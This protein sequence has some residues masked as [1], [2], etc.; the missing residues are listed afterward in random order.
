[1]PIVNNL[2]MKLDGQNILVYPYTV[3]R[4]VYINESNGYNLIQAL[5]DLRN[6][7]T[8]EW[9]DV[10]NKPFSAIGTDFKVVDG[11][12]RLNG[13]FSMEWSE[14]QN[15]PTVFNS[16]WGRITGKPTMYP[17]DWSM[18]TN[19]PSIYNSDWESVANKPEIFLTNWNSINEKP[20][21]FDSEWFAMNNKPFNLINGL[22][23]YVDTNDHLNI[24]QINNRKFVR[25]TDSFDN[26]TIE[27]NIPYILYN[28]QVDENNCLLE[29]LNLP[30]MMGVRFVGST[31]DAKND[32]DFY[33]ANDLGIKS[34]YYL[35]IDNNTHDYSKKYILPANSSHFFSIP[36][37]FNFYTRGN[38]NIQNSCGL[39][40]FDFNYI[41][42][43]CYLFDHCNLNGLGQIFFNYFPT[44]NANLSNLFYN[45]FDNRH[46]ELLNLTFNNL[47]YNG[48]DSNNFSNLF[49]SEKPYNINCISIDNTSFIWI[50]DST[51]QIYRL[52][53]NNVN[54][55]IVYINGN[56]NF[57]NTALALSKQQ[58][59]LNYLSFMWANVQTGWNGG[60]QLPPVLLYN[61]YF[62]TVN[63][64]NAEYMPATYNGNGDIRINC[65]DSYTGNPPQLAVINRW[66][67][68]SDKTYINVY[69]SS[70]S[71][72]PKNMLHMDL[73]QEHRS[74]MFNQSNVI[75]NAQI[76]GL[77]FYNTS[78]QVYFPFHANQYTIQ[79]PSFTLHFK[80]NNTADS[81]WIY[82]PDGDC[83][84]VYDGDP[85]TLTKLEICFE[86]YPNLESDP[87]YTYFTKTF[88]QITLNFINCT[89]NYG[90]FMV[91]DFLGYSSGGT[92]RTNIINICG[93]ASS[94]A[95]IH[96]L[97]LSG[98]TLIKNINLVNIQQNFYGL[99]YIDEFEWDYAPFNNDITII[100]PDETS[101]NR[102]D[103][104]TS[105][106]GS[107]GILVANNTYRKNI[108]IH[109]YTDLDQRWGNTEQALKDFFNI[110][111]PN[112][113]ANCNKSFITGGNGYIYSDYNLYIYNNTK[114][115]FSF[116]M[117]GTNYL[118]LYPY[119]SN[120][121]NIQVTNILPPAGDTT[122]YVYFGNF[123]PYKP[124][125]TNSYI[126]LLENGGEVLYL[127][128]NDA[129]TANSTLHYPV[130]GKSDIFYDLVTAV[131]E[132]FAAGDDIINFM[133]NLSYIPGAVYGGIEFFNAGQVIIN[134]SVNFTNA[135]AIRYLYSGSSVKH[136]FI[137]D[138]VTDITGMYYNC[139]YLTGKGK[140]PN[141]VTKMNQ[142]YLNCQNITS[143]EIGPNVRDSAQAFSNCSNLRSFTFY[144]TSNFGFQTFYQCY[145][146]NGA[147]HFDNF[148]G[149]MDL[150]VF[151]N[152]NIEEMY[153]TG[154]DIGEPYSIQGPCNSASNLR[155]VEVGLQYLINGTINRLGDPGYPLYQLE[156]IIIN[157]N[158]YIEGSRANGN[159]ASYMFGHSGTGE[160]PKLL[161]IPAC[162]KNDVGF[163]VGVT[164]W[165]APN[166]VIG[167]YTGNFP[168]TDQYMQS[169][170]CNNNTVIMAIGNYYQI[171]YGLSGYMEN[172]VM[173]TRPEKFGNWYNAKGVS[174]RNGL[175]DLV[176]GIVPF[177][178]N[179][180][181]SI[182]NQY[183]NV[184]YS[185][186]GC[187]NMIFPTLNDDYENFLMC[188]VYYSFGSDNNLVLAVGPSGKYGYYKNIDSSYNY[189]PNLKIVVGGLYS[190][191]NITWSFCECNGNIKALYGQYANIYSSFN[192][193]V[194]TTGNFIVNSQNILYSFVGAKANL[195][196]L[197]VGNFQYSFNNANC[198]SIIGNICNGE[199]G[200]YWVNNLQYVGINIIENKDRY[201][202]WSGNTAI[203]ADHMFKW[204]PNLL[205]GEVNI[206]FN[207][208]ENCNIF[209]SGAGG[210]GIFE[211]C[212]NMTDIN[213]SLTAPADYPNLNNLYY[214][215][216]SRF[217]F[218]QKP[219]LTT[220]NLLCLPA[221][222]SFLFYND[223][224]LQQINLLLDSGTDQCQTVEQMFLNCYALREPFIFNNVTSMNYTY[225]N[226][227]NLVNSVC[228]PNVIY[229]SHAYEGCSSLYNAN[230]GESVEDLTRAFAGCINLNNIVIINSP[231]VNIIQQP[232]EY[233]E[234]GYQFYVPAGSITNER[235]FEMGNDQSG[236]PIP[237][238]FA[239]TPS[240]IVY[241]TWTLDPD[242]SCYYDAIHNIY[243][244][245]TL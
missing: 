104:F 190:P 64:P 228:G 240:E 122:N 17:S 95:S 78:G 201:V 227:T 233:F 160:M 178:L 92:Q 24:L 137:P 72:Y 197:E 67:P 187:N 170:V 114:S 40:D 76:K 218:N 121:K 39:I 154:T 172:I 16:S 66:T 105:R 229:M 18:I 222:C 134:N 11:Q 174:T 51:P 219:Y 41:E 192:N 47:R 84:W 86:N 150:G 161:Y 145:N 181:A 144:N 58:N 28:I 146:L 169:N 119:N 237:Y 186:W 3:G 107:G 65:T 68:F 157:D 241:A 207:S 7:A 93:D 193:S 153:F 79:D 180:Y 140:C 75:F 205:K 100:F 9:N 166:M 1:M 215:I 148:K 177:S 62:S 59:V 214:N 120:I 23:F 36:Y 189:C 50:N 225:A 46:Y 38:N 4:A 110:I 235:F 34:S 77:V 48:F 176:Y 49:Y 42:N 155:Y 208:I 139:I 191:I 123:T 45:C 159:A 163:G 138:S 43:A 80:F 118:H 223:A 136:S 35:F 147:V 127:Y 33:I 124:N 29:S 171:P 106:Y 71:S 199:S 238:V 8:S 141:Q 101:Y 188:A 103:D 60:L 142:A 132:P 195:I 242:N 13:S 125:V 143:G 126:N 151:F 85:T 156:S 27:G 210:H 113:I 10:K 152:A 243:V 133:N 5:A 234:N 165:A 19:Q 245:Y 158:D 216:I 83:N 164:C 109:G 204:C 20:E 44:K 55:N 52:V 111:D 22:D 81:S 232:F 82:W 173:D 167:G 88:N 90:N 211:G 61:F 30:E 198:N 87:E 74:G 98:A 196:Q 116:I 31:L 182:P 175:M 108:Y 200:F 183:F 12:L 130:S 69:G 226:C 32:I 99:N 6:N 230:I 15:K 220:L 26:E 73:R 96:N 209:G 244:Y 131:T 212:N 221:Y 135:S 179:K 202:D 54:V 213:I 236:H 239:N 217:C 70:L 206:I 56:V 194:N 97:S 115:T 203:G 89:F 2:I 117:G 37:S 128:I 184:Q 168:A 91:T 94:F 224:N 112:I 185:Y 14:I 129:D 149:R 231:N 57:I 53:S 63:I 162:T 25:V 21:Y 102:G